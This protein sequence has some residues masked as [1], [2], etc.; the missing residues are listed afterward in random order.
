MNILV[1]GFSR[2]TRSFHTKGTVTLNTYLIRL[3]TEGFCQATVNGIT[4]DI[5]PGDLL[6]CRPEDKYE[7]RI[8]INEK[9]PIPSA[10]YYLTIEAG[11]TW[12]EQWCEDYVH[13]VI[14]NIIDIDEMLISIWKHLVYENRRVKDA[15]QNIL[16][17][18]SRGMLLHLKRLIASGE[19]DG[20]AYERSVSNQIKLFVET[21]ATESIQLKDAAAFVGL[22]ISRASQLFKETFNQSIMD[23]AIEVRLAIARERILFSG[24][25]L[26]E[27]AYQC[28]FANYTHFNRLFRS[29][30][31]M[32][33]SE[34]KRQLKGNTRRL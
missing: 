29:R 33:P 6:L 11:A 7:L 23:Y 17:F 34:Y 24:T 3:Q 10:D 2:H 21:H 19:N 12:I 22:S 32:S 25:T 9:N 16:D 31:N 13:T 15:D 1:A 18:M 20:N 4:Y 30:F 5:R 14:F 26:Q 8:P 27:V 28:G